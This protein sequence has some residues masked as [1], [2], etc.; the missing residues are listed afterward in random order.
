ME[1]TRT[2][3]H[4]RLLSFLSQT[5]TTTRE[6]RAKQLADRFSPFFLNVSQL[7]ARNCDAALRVNLALHTREQPAAA[8]VSN[9]LALHR[10]SLGHPP[11]SSFHH[12]PFIHHSFFGGIFVSSSFLPSASTLFV[13]VFYSSRVC[14]PIFFSFFLVA[15]TKTRKVFV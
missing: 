6:G 14:A 9:L 7:L 1:I 11:P 12:S 3:A 10:L 8:D 5:A 2:H 4:I 13:F 15:H